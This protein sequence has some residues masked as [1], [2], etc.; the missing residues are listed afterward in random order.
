MRSRNLISIAFCG[1]LAVSALAGEDDTG[2]TLGDG[3]LLYATGHHLAGQPIPAVEDPYGY[4]YQDHAFKGSYANAYLGRD[5]FA[6]YQGDDEAYLGANPGAANTWYWPYRGIHLLMK[7]NDVWLSNQ[8]CDGDGKLDRYRG[9]SSYIGSGAFCANH[10]SGEY[11]DADG[12][13]CQWS[14]LATIAAAPA[15]SVAVGGTW[16]AADGTEIGPVVWGAFAVVQKIEN[17]PCATL[18]GHHYISLVA[19]GL[20]AF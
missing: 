16:Y 19:P 17:D 9:F 5:G 20:G 11:E 12:N 4:N 8:D 14:Y 2:T 18:H 1:V 15:D 10:Q 3:T 6:P 7:W 13:A